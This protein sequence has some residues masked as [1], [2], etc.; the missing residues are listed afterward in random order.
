MSNVTVG[1]LRGQIPYLEEHIKQKKEICYRY[2]ERL[3]GLPMSM[4]PIPANCEPNYWLS[5][6]LI[7]QDAMCKQ[8]RGERESLYVSEPGKSYPTKILEALAAYI[9]TG[10]NDIDTEK[11]CLLE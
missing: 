3:K 2:K 10:K 6:A 1:V 9:E 11:C 8:M 5:C 4:N 7:D